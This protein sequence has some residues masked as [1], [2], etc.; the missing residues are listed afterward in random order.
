MINEEK[1][2]VHSLFSKNVGENITDDKAYIKNGRQ[3]S[4]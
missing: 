1:V 3:P 4:I 2:Q